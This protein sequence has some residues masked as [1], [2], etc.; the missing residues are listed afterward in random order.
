MRARCWN[1]IIAKEKEVYME[2][3]QNLQEIIEYAEEHLQRKELPID[4]EQV[5]KMAGCSYDFFQKVFSYM[6][7]ISFSEYIRNRKLTLSGYDLKST[8]MKVIDISYKYGYDSPTSFTK[9]FKKFHGISPQEARGSNAEL[10]VYPKMQLALKE[11]YA[12]KLSKREG[13]R[14]I[15]K[16]IKLSSNHSAQLEIP[17]FWNDCQ[18]D[19]TFLKLISL[20]E[21]QVKGLFGVI[22]E[23][24]EKSDAFNYSIMV[25]SNQK[26]PEGYEELIIPTETWAIFDCFGPVPESIQKGWT[27][28][29]NEWVVKYPFEHGHSPE[30]EW[31]S[32]GNPFDKQYLSQLWIPIKEDQ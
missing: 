31:Y 1:D 27:Y 30:L 19:G 3:N 18:R 6:N 23:F 7:G 28:L 17:K 12:W 14:L 16:S 32:D 5:A 25:I 26:T 21:S 20:D 9:A 13:F 10:K 24:D 22:S 11:K 15:G 8:S 2:W 4:T 29:K